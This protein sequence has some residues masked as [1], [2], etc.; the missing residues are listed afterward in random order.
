MKDMLKKAI[1]IFMCLCGLSILPAPA[2]LSSPYEG[3]KNSPIETNDGTVFKAPSGER[4]I[5]NQ[6]DGIKPFGTEDYPLLRAKPGEGTGQKEGSISDGMW[7]IA[8]LS[9]TYGIVHRRHRK[10][11]EVDF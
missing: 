7:I 10:K 11:G 4:T 2:N 8:L 3:W 6:E 1:I 9:I 5:W